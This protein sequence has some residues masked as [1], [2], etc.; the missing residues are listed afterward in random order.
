MM[1]GKNSPHNSI[2]LREGLQHFHVIPKPLKSGTHISDRLWLCDWFKDWTE[3][4]FLHLGSSDEFFVWIVR[5]QNYQDDRIWAKNVEYIEEDE[6]IYEIIR[7]QACI[8]VFIMFTCKRLLWVIKDKG[9]SWTGQYFHD[10]ILTEH[11][12]PFLKN[13]EHVIDPDEVIFV[14]DKA[15][16]MRA[17]RTQHLFQDNDVKFWDNDT[18][19]ENSTDLNMTEILGQ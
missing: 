12:I 18:W 16:C 10:V 2:R 14:Y 19:P 5:R 11:V 15:I 4:H 1:Y 13:E 9:E 8:K 3:Q 17:N 6:R 7:H